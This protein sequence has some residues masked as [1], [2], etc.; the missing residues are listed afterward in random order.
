MALN[1]R[2]VNVQPAWGCSRLILKVQ[3]I[4]GLYLAGLDLVSYHILCVTEE[5]EMFVFSLL[6]RIR[7]MKT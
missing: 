1:E 3:Q 5:R 2:L 6:Y 7:I 4:T